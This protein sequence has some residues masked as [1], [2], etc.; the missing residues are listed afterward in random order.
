[1]GAWD[2]GG[3]KKGYFGQAPGMLLPPLRNCYIIITTMQLCQT[4]LPRISTLQAWLQRFA[5]T[6][7]NLIHKDKQ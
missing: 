1:M 3:G 5:S 2:G 6:R 4:L 7:E